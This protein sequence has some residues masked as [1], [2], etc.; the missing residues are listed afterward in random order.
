VAGTT[1]RAELAAVSI[2]VLMAGIAI[3][4]CALVNIVYMATCTGNRGMRAAKFE[5]GQVMVKSGWF[6]GV[7]CMTGTTI[8]SKT[9]SVSVVLFVA[10][11]AVA[12]CSLVDIV[13]V[14]AG[15]GNRGMRAAKFECGQVMVKRGWFPGSGG[16]AGTAVCA[17]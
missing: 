8:R 15:T 13:D 16:V 12:G 14:T 17:E 3:A 5:C 6:P 4:G 10:G 7:C 2:V 11:I 9:A 1:V